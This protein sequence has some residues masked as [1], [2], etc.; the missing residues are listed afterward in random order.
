MATT[1]RDFEV[2]VKAADEDRTVVVTVYPIAGRQLFFRIPDSFCRECELTHRLV[3]QVT[4]ELRDTDPR[5]KVEVKPWVN[6]LLQALR[7]GGWHPPVVTINGRLFSQGVVPDRDALK[8]ALLQA[9]GTAAPGPAD[10]T[11]TG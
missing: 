9:R 1:T 6:N 4:E 5:I 3:G 11:S 7:R 2:P 8:T 10:H